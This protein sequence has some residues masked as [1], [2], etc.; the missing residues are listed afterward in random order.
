MFVPLEH[1]RI[2]LG[3]SHTSPTNHQQNPS[4][5]GYTVHV[6]CLYAAISVKLSQQ[7][8]KSSN[9]SAKGLSRK[10]SFIPETLPFIGFL[11]S[12]KLDHAFL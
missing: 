8:G 6:Y 12:L 4:I 2:A 9:M 5:G 3:K 1:C 7:Q 10:T 11:L